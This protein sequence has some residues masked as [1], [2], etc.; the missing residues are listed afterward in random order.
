MN[1][2]RGAFP[3][4]LG[5]KPEKSIHHDEIRSASYGR[6]GTGAYGL[7][8]CKARQ[9]GGRG[10]PSPCHQTS[11]GGVCESWARRDRKPRSDEGEDQDAAV[12]CVPP[13]FPAG[14]VRDEPGQG[15]VVRPQ[16]VQGGKGGGKPRRGWRTE[17]CRIGRDRNGVFEV[18]PSAFW[19]LCCRMGYQSCDPARSGLRWP[20]RV[21]RL[22]LVCCPMEK[23]FCD[24]R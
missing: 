12:R 13:R 10:C 4:P 5:A 9:G 23:W 3:T 7:T 14:F 24:G 15:V 11:P 19:R 20:L 22:P 16:A 6:R 21:L 1:F 18:V 8:E 2:W 17:P